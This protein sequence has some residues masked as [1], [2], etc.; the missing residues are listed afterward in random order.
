[1]SLDADSV[2]QEIIKFAGPHFIYANIEMQYGGLC[3]NDQ[4]GIPVNFL[5]F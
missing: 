3:E 4:P 2:Y 1:M 5:T